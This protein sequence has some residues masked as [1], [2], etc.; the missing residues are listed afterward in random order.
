MSEWDHKHESV[1]TFV[2]THYK[3]GGDRV[4]CKHCGKLGPKEANCCEDVGYPVG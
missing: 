1:D 2:V 3:G 4:S